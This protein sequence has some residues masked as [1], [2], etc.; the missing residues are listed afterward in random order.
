MTDGFMR[1]IRLTPALLA[2]LAAIS[3][4]AGCS[5]VQN[6]LG[7]TRKPPDEFQVYSRPDL[8]V[9]PDFDLRPPQPGAPPAYAPDL[10]EEAASTVFRQGN[11]GRAVM[12]ARNIEGADRSVGEMALMDSAGTDRANPDIRTVVDREAGQLVLEDKQFADRLIFWQNQQGPET[13]IDPAAEAARLAGNR[14]GGRPI[15][16]GETPTIER[17]HRAP[18]EGLIPGTY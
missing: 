2:G 4:L 16:E 17:K 9:P 18:L 3:A 6:E 11:N 7:I 5:K 1:K 12:S 8:R 15:T 13:V 14:A 10:N